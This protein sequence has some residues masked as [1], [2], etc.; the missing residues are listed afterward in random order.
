LRHIYVWLNFRD[1]IKR[2]LS[3][4]YLTCDEV[5]EYITEHKLFTEAEGSDTPL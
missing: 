2:C 1:C 4:K 5:I 3:I